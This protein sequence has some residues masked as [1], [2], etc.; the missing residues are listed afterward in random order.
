MC[1]HAKPMALRVVGIYAYSYLHFG[2]KREVLL[3]LLGTDPSD[4]L[5][6]VAFGKDSV[7][8]KAVISAAFRVSCH[9]ESTLAPPPPKAGIPPPKRVRRA[10]TGELESRVLVSHRYPSDKAITQLKSRIMKCALNCS[11]ST[12]TSI[13][14][15]PKVDNT[16]H[17]SE[18]RVRKDLVSGC[19]AMLKVLG[20]KSPRYAELYSASGL[21][22]SV[23]AIQE[24]LFVTRSSNCTVLR[25]HLKDSERLLAWC[26]SI[27]RDIDD[28]SPIKVA[29]FIRDQLPRGKSVPSR[30]LSTLVWFQRV[31]DIPLYVSDPIVVSV[32]GC[33]V[34]SPT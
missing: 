14:D 34:Q 15:I 20:S 29:S 2:S 4:H 19:F 3:S 33:H 28:L 17:E 5:I 18:S 26:V 22:E 30:V 16:L 12:F 24:D 11:P 23:M 9:K 8:H 13:A 25:N 27:G 10:D 31:F 32:Q 7:D 6:S 1:V 21:D